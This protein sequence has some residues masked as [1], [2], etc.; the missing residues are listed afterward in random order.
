MA[1]PFSS[2]C[3]KTQNINEGLLPK[4]LLAKQTWHTQCDRSF[5]CLWL[6]LHHCFPLYC[7]SGGLIG[8]NWTF[9]RQL[10]DRLGEGRLKMDL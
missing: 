10:L 5:R 9:R 6:Y 3:S 1:I 2:V 8:L 7:P 4:A